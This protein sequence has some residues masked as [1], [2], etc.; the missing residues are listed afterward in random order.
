[1]NDDVTG[2]RYGY[3][4][5]NFADPSAVYK[6]IED[7]DHLINGHLV[8]VRKSELKVRWLDQEHFQTNRLYVYL[9][10]KNVSLDA[11]AT[12][13]GEYGKVISCRI[14]R[15]KHYGCV[16][17]Q[18]EKTVD[19]IL[20]AH[21]NWINFRGRV[22]LEI[23]K[24]KIKRHLINA[25]RSGQGGDSGARESSGLRD[26][27]RRVVQNQLWQPHGSHR[28]VYGSGGEGAM[29]PSI[30]LPNSTRYGS[31]YASPTMY[32]PQYGIPS[33]YGYDIAAH[34]GRYGGQNVVGR[35]GVST[36]GASGSGGSS[37]ARQDDNSNSLFSY[38]MVTQGASR[39]GGP[40]NASK[41]D[42]P[43]SLGKFSIIK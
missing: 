12:F 21:G 2:Q 42:N 30:A 4:F 36:Q 40:S 22:M 9:I 14:E 10:P 27:N 31:Y 34:A 16:Y 7:N 11:L 39:S 1:M 17:F 24:H 28:N 37:N 8:A 3:G 35:A 38:Q 25:S 32:G 18:S 43:E 13:F 23:S 20:A 29:V 19:D 6:A 15:D 5:V 26:G 41:D 33:H